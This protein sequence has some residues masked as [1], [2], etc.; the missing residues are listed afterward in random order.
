MVKNPLARAGDVR[1]SGSTPELGRSPGEGN[2]NPLQ[3]SHPG[4]P[5]DRGA[6][7]AT[8]SWGHKESD[9]TEHTPT[10]ASLPG[11]IH[12]QRSLVGYSSRSHKR[13]RRYLEAKQQQIS[14]LRCKESH[15]TEQLRHA[16][17][18]EYSP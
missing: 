8:I 16:R 15:T 12:G 11:E 1:D 13:V 18:L 9:T 6:W 17:V 3:H 5:R 10:P 4:N 2:G 14:E 7:W